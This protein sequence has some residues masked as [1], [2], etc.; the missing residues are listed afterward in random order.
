MIPADNSSITADI[1]MVSSPIFPACLFILSATSSI[2]DE[3]SFNCFMIFCNFSTK[4]FTPV[5]SC[6]I[7]SIRFTGIR[8]LKSPVPFWISSTIWFNCRLAFFNGLIIALFTSMY[9]IAQI[10]RK[11]IPIVT[12]I[13]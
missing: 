1:F 9:A 10:S 3:P 8:M 5:T 2:S 12:L 13:R 6:P 11:Q 4:R 7:S